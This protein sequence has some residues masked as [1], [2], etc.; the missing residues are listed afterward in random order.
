MTLSGGIR[1]V[2]CVCELHL[3]PTVALR[4]T[5]RHLA[6]TLPGC[7]CRGSGLVEVAYADSSLRVFR[8]PSTGSVT[9]Q[10]RRRGLEQLLGPRWRQAAEGAS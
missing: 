10:A 8:A 6:C 7:A 9:V 3:S 2:C 4:T 1:L 5:P